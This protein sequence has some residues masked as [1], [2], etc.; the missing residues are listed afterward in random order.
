MS[1]EQEN[2]S[3]LFA[4][5]LKGLMDETDLFT[6]P[7]W[8]KLLSVITEEDLENWVSDRSIPMKANLFVLVNT[9]LWSDVK[10][11]EPLAA[12]DRIKDLPATEVSPLGRFM[13]PSIA[14]Y[15]NSPTIRGE[16]RD[17]FPWR[18]E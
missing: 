14:E 16:D 6:R 1:R 10:N 4:Q 17:T 13:R 18:V 3:S 7:E 5:S 15:M 8:A 2:P 11:E 12:F 9:V